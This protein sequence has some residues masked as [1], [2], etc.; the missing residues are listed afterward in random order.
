MAPVGG[1]G[2]DRTAQGEPS[3]PTPPEAAEAPIT[4]AARENPGPPPPADT[5]FDLDESGLVRPSPDGTV[6]PTGVI[7][8]EGPPPVVPPATPERPDAL[9]PAETAPET[10]APGE[11]A[12]EAALEEAL[13]GAAEATTETPP[14]AETDPDTRPEPRPDG[15]PEPDE[16]APDTA[17]PD[18]TDPDTP[19]DAQLTPEPGPGAAADGTEVAG[20]D[21]E[22]AVDVAATTIVDATELAVSASLKP[23]GR[24]ANIDAIVRAATARA[25]AEPA[26]AVPAAATTTPA[27]PTSASV[28]NQATT[29]NAINLRE[30]NLLGISGP[31]NARRALVRMANGRYVTVKVGDRL[32][33]GRVTSISADGLTYQKGARNFTLQLLPLG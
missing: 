23:T 11:A 33:G 30:I 29:S 15:A 27:I 24:P 10:G 8:F 19:D 32:D 7:V 18:A 4:F 12:L 5:V 16:P 26:P 22:G 17:A 2:R 25:A 20:L 31:S 14:A 13:E 9:A 6:S 28:A 21:V 3:V 1:P